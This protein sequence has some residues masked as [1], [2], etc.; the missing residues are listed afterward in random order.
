[1]GTNLQ[2]QE[3]AAEEVVT[4]VVRAALATRPKD[5]TLLRMT[6]DLEDGMVGRM[7]TC[8]KELGRFIQAVVL[9]QFSPE[10]NYAQAFKFLEDRS[11]DGSDSLYGCIWD[12]AV[13]E[14]AMSLHTKRGEVARRREALHCTWQLELNTNNDEEILNEAANVRRAMFLRSL[15]AQFF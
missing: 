1:M 6:A 12:M 7:V 5:P 9:S 3:R 8:V 11:V 4:R 15:S 2:V 14:F 10:P 13:L